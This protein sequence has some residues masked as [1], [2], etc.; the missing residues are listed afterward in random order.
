LLREQVGLFEHLHAHLPVFAGHHHL[1]QRL[2]LG[3][4]LRK[5]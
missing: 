2:E 4:D 5:K 1:S 3:W